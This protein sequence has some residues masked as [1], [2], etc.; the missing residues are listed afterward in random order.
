MPKEI[1]LNGSLVPGLGEGRHF[2]AAQG[3]LEQFISALGI[4]PY[5]GTLN[6]KLAPE[7]VHDFELLKS[8]K[9]IRIS[10]FTQGGKQFGGVS[11]FKAKILG[12]ECAV[13]IPDKS[14]YSDV[15]EVISD[16][17]LRESTGLKDGDKI[18][19]LVTL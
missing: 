12:V 1:V 17:N 11:L 2:M 7:C 19:L 18:T 13:V 3:Y 6:I 16:R 5:P 4:K 8:Q 15:V 9:G 10:G 14:R